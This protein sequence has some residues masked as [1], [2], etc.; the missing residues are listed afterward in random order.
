MTSEKTP[1]VPMLV[2]EAEIIC[3]RVPSCGFRVPFD[4]FEKKRRFPARICARCNGPVQVVVAATD[5]PAPFVVSVGGGLVPAVGGASLEM[6]SIAAATAVLGYDLLQGATFATAQY[7]RRVVAAGLAG[8]AAALD[9][10]IDLM[11]DNILI[12]V[13]YNTSVGAP[14]RDVDMYRVGEPVPP[15]TTLRALVT[16]APATNPLN[17]AVDVIRV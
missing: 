4:Y 15:G 3:A 1:V 7:D 16:D 9:S 12:A 2:T 17:L 6:V 8:S 5:L 10:K 11:V 13:M 14:T